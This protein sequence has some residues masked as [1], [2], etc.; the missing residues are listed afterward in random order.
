MDYTRAKGNITELQCIS[1]FFEYGIECSV[2]Y[3]NGAK[4]DFIADIKGS[5]IRIQCKSSTKIDENSF[6]F[7]CMN[8][9]SNT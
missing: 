3:G 5:L 9:T 6:M 2:P 7:V 8:Q 4:Y 1:K